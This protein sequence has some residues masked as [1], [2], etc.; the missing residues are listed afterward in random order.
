MK[1]IRLI[2][3][4][5]LITLFACGKH[6][7]SP[8]DQIVTLLDQAT[9]KTQNITSV[10]QLNDVQ[11]IISPEDVWNIIQENANYKLSNSDKDHLKKSYD[12]LVRVAYEKSCEFVS[13]DEMKK[14]MKN[15]LDLLM[16]G[17]KKNIDNAETL[18][19]IRP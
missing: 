6:E 2:L 5:L 12:K 10:A 9:E 4:L 19:E 11:N 18:G 3:P 7:D 14:L 16:E 1:T 17:I 13:S 15:Q 8:V